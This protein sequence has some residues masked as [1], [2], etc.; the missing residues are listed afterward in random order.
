VTYAQPTQPPFK[1]TE[2]HF[3]AK[4]LKP[5]TGA[6]LAYWSYGL[7][8]GGPALA[9]TQLPFAELIMIPAALVAAL[10]GFYAIFKLRED[11]R[12]RRRATA[13]ACIGSA[14]GT[15]LFLLMLVVVL[16]DAFRG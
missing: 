13:A 11:L 12:G 3:E 14:A 8:I 5:S 2:P 9:L 15:T 7:A 10:L 4:R 1:P 6:R 16:V